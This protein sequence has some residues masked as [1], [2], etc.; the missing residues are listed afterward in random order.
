LIL[1]HGWNDAAL[2]PTNT[3]NYYQS[4]VAKLGQRQANSFLRLYMAPGVQHCFG[5]PGPDRFGQ[6]VTRAQSD[7]QHEMTLALERWVEQGVAPEMIIATKRQ[8]ANPES[9]ILRTRPLCP[10]PKVARYK[11]SGGTDEAAN[12]NCVMERPDEKRKR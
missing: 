3:V 1:Y 2:P 4:V 7:P 10:Y 8:S 9:P 5:G 6:T 11:G 12:F